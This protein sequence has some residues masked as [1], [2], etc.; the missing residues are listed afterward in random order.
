[1]LQDKKALC[2]ILT[3]CFIPTLCLKFH[4]ITDDLSQA[5]PKKKKELRYSECYVTVGFV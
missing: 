4:T 3:L 1:M 2:K 5:L